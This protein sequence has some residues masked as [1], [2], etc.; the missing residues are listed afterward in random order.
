[1]SVGNELESKR[2]KKE[3]CESVKKLTYNALKLLLIF[4]F[5]CLFFDISNFISMLR[6]YLYT[7]T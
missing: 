4:F 7:E 3:T 6:N 1:M 5:M 2:S